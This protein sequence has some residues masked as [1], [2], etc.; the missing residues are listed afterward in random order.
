M[1]L[2]RMRLWYVRI[3]SSNEDVANQDTVMTIL[4]IFHMTGDM[5]GVPWGLVV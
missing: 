3:R 2:W 4:Y 1:L 5:A